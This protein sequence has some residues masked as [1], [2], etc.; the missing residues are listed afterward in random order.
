MPKPAEF[1]VHPAAN[2]LP[3]MTEEKIAEL[4]RD[5]EQ[6]GQLF[7]IIVHERQILDGRNRLAACRLVQRDPWFEQWDGRGGSPTAFAASANLPRR[8]LTKDQLAMAGRD[9]IPLFEAEA[10][11]RMKAG[12]K[13]QTLPPRGRKGGDGDKAQAA[14]TAT[15]PA[16]EV[17]GSSAS[18]AAEVVGVGTRSVERA[19]MIDTKRPDLAQLIREGKSSLKKAEKAIKR[20]EQ[21]KQ[22]LEY[23]PP[24][25]SYAV[26]VT[27]VPWK[28]DDQLDGSDAVR[29]GLTYPPMEL[30]EILKMKVPA[31]GDCALWFWTTNAF[32]MDGT[33]AR[34]LA[35][36]GFTPK[37]ILTWC[38]TTK[39]GDEPRLGSG[40]YLRN[41]TEHCILAVRGKPVIRGEK[42]ATH[43][44]APRTL[45]HSQKPDAFFKIV[46]A[47]CP[48][49]PEARLELFAREPRDGWVTSGA[50]LPKPS[51]QLGAREAAPEAIDYIERLTDR[52]WEPILGGGWGKVIA[53]RHWVVDATAE[54]TSRHTPWAA[55]QPA[56]E[57]TRSRRLG[58]F[59]TIEEAVEAVE[60]AA[61]SKAP[62]PAPPGAPPPAKVRKI[63]IT[64][65]R[66]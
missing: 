60:K 6:H 43:F 11:A 5:I 37:S 58:D 56:S 15:P 55:Y 22:V 23:R 4:A 3:M 53:D 44:E 45:V 9:F 65:D 50:E 54:R 64:V 16:K 14:E 63:V 47:V 36:W 1:K 57:T 30:E 13:A 66:S 31:A 8:H 17:K 19:K 26:V 24:K 29:G 21:V 32:L 52:G 42:Q 51:K 46:E 59:A 35:E 18:K 38:K 49:P 7:P 20:E 39:D 48:C 10:K 27:D 40:H 12:R 33:A 61:R 41:S 28:Y 34:V 2:V 62:A 25:G